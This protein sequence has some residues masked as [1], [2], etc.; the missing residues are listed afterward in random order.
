MSVGLSVSVC[1]LPVGLSIVCRRAWLC[2]CMCVR[3][4]HI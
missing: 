2:A 1:Y 4:V 3:G